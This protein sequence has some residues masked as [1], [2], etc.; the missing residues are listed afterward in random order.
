VGIK[1]GKRESKSRAAEHNPAF[2]IKANGPT[3]IT[4]EGKENDGGTHQTASSTS[5]QEEN[6]NVGVGPPGKKGSV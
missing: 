1:G 5:K 3:V 4:S 6:C 2:I